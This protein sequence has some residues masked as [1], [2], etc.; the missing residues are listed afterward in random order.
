MPRIES[1]DFSMKLA[2]SGDVVETDYLV[3]GA[4]AAGMAFTDALLMHSDATVTLV[5]RRH[6]PGGH[7][8]DAYP[9][10]RLHQ[11]SA[12]YGVDS[13]PLGN[14]AIERSGLNAG[15]HE[16]AGPDE[17]RA[18][19]DRVMQQHFLPTGRVRFL[20]CTDY[21]G[22][23]GG[24]HR[25]VSRLTGSAREVRV[26]RKLV[27]T[28][29]M[30]GAI[31]ATSKPPFEVAP[32]VRFVPAGGVAGMEDGALRY[33]VIGAGKTA[34]DTCVWLL[35][36]GVPPDRI[37]WIKPREAWWL[38]R[39]YH[40]P[41][42]MLPDFYAGGGLQ[43]QAMARA[44]SIDDMFAR[45]EA[46]GFFLRVDPAVPATMLHGAIVSEAEVEQLRRIRDVVRLGRV[47]RIERDRIVLDEGEVPTDE[48]TVHVHCAAQGLRHP[49]LR[50]VFEADRVT[51]QPTAWG[52]YS[53]QIELLGVVEAL[54]GSDDEKN[55]LCPPIV[56]WDRPADYLS[57]YL[58]LLAGER[59]RA[60]YPAVAAWAKGSRLNP[61]GGLGKYREDARVLA[62]KEVFK[63]V[64][65][66]AVA[67]AGRMVAVAG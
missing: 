12:F 35:G 56:Y 23:E 45:L 14:D 24:S 62:T 34:L 52:F 42:D 33:C 30:E 59:A 19:Y 58:A 22:T 3:V 61:L 44:S 40:Q 29:Y 18:Y 21:A 37:R 1:G 4:G 28:T 46:D 64:A 20:P 65:S 8:L 27:D 49:P 38:N 63:Q 2:A 7:W 57:A 25:I 47:R 17:L 5:D 26:R 9:F 55:R 48:G 54:V 51:V 11:P 36:Q 16:M 41:H 15:F 6:A 32:G 39:R 60:A 66:A 13:V 10:V 53:F 31:P 50:P 67:N 43:M